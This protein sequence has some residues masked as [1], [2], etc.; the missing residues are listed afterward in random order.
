MKFTPNLTR[1]EQKYGFIALVL[2]MVVLP[3]LLVFALPGASTARLNFINY[4]IFAAVA[5]Y[6]LRGFLTRNLAAALRS[7][8]LTLY[9]AALGYLAHTVL[10]ELS[11]MLIYTFSNHYVNLND[12][13]I[14]S[15]IG[16]E[17]RLMLVTTVILAPI[18]EECLFRGLLF[19]GLYDRSPA[20][21]WI[22]SAVLFSAV[23]VVGFIGVY[24]PL[25][26][27][28]AFIQYLP[29]GVA[30]CFAYQR[31]GSIFSPI[32]T[33]AIINLMAFYSVTR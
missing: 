15:Q 3:G 1:N 13:N 5:V 24:A 23:H 10:S 12:Q 18:A 16:D 20:A 21:A 26:L 8:F 28:L 7:P 31:G 4:F 33:H 32:L 29:A 17:M 14:V 30:L 22:L 6:V 19:R 2:S 27:A 25:T 9:Y 11:A